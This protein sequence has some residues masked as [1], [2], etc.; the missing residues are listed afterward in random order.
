MIFAITVTNTVQL[1]KIPLFREWSY[2]KVLFQSVQ[3][4]CIHHVDYQRYVVTVEL[5]QPIGLVLLES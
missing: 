1:T 3:A 4:Q 5:R 2:L